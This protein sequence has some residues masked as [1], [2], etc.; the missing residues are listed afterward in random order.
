MIWLIVDDMDLFME[1]IN[2]NIMNLF[3]YFKDVIVMI[4]FIRCCLMEVIVI[5][6]AFVYDARLYI[7]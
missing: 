2:F 1:L 5:I 4:V 7:F 6:N 3:I